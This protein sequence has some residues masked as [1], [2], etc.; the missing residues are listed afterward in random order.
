MQIPDSRRRPR[1]VDSRPP[2][3]P[4]SHRP[5]LT[6]QQSSP[7]GGPAARTA[8]VGGVAVAVVLAAIGGGGSALFTQ[9]QA[10]LDFGAGVLALVSLSATV[11]WGLAATDRMFFRPSHRLLAQGVHRATAVSGIAFL[12]L[13]VWVK[14]SL[15]RTG[16]AAVAVPFLDVTKPVLI[17]LGTIAGYLFVAVAVS[18]AMRSVFTSD[19]ARARRWRF[20]HMCAYP[21]WGAALVH[22]LKAGRPA[23]SHITA[24]YALAVIAVAVALVLRGRAKPGSPAAR[25]PRA[26]HGELPRPER[27]GT[28]DLPERPSQDPVGLLARTGSHGGRRTGGGLGPGDGDRPWPMSV[29][30]P[31]AGERGDPRRPARERSLLEGG[32]D[33]P[34]PGHLP[35]PGA[36]PSGSA[37]G[38]A[39]GPADRRPGPL[40]GPPPEPE[41]L[42]RWERDR[43]GSWGGAPLTA[44]GPAGASP[45]APWP[46]CP[47]PGP[48]ASPWSS[49]Q[50]PGG[51]PWAPATGEPRS[52]R[53]VNGRAQQ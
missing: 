20:L 23:A 28:P 21:A 14:V 32:K 52:G 2:S 36:T 27:R 43:T 12:A 53:R 44:P 48:A 46:R 49:A 6:P 30:A 31:A 24:A 45:G 29:P 25:G 19:P 33:L 40:P 3:P 16:A 17:G 35:W 7:P 42:S 9:T 18:G 47:E 8:A 50:P 11:L 15:G 38:A 34:R 41:R 51:G 5:R 10:F 13:H 39:A 22:G 37:S 1:P 4:S 26:P